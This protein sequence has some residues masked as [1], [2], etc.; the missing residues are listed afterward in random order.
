MSEKLTTEAF[1]V[2]V[3]LLVDE[4][5]EGFTRTKIGEYEVRLCNANHAIDKLV[6]LVE[7]WQDPSNRWSPALRSYEVGDVVEQDGVKLVVTHTDFNPDTEVTQEYRDAWTPYPPDRQTADIEKVTRLMLDTQDALVD[8][9]KRL[10]GLWSE[11]SKLL[12]EHREITPLRGRVNS[13]GG[14]IVTL[15]KRLDRVEAIANAVDKHQLDHDNRIVVL[16]K[17]VKGL[18]D[19]E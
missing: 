6:A 18:L 15:L 14:E 10:E 17:Q 3:C 16:Q 5:R 12:S 1:V 8:R 13:L 9:V 4:I 2:E 7:R 11:G 19:R